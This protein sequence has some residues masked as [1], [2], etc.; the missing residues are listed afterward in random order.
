M[1]FYIKGVI[2]STSV[3]KAVAIPGFY[4]NLLIIFDSIPMGTVISAI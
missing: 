2:F 3:P 4:Q 1:G